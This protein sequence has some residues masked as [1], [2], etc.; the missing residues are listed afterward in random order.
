MYF[1][2]PKIHTTTQKPQKR[3]I[4]SVQT[5][6]DIYFFGIIITSIKDTYSLYFYMYLHETEPRS[7]ENLHILT[8]PLYVDI[9]QIYTHI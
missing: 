6:Q 4:V 3:L 5:R 2:L 8:S 9:K 1:L 7:V